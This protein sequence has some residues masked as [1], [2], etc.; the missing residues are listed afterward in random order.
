MITD[1]DLIKAWDRI[2]RTPDGALIYRYF[3][4]IIMGNLDDLDPSDRALRSHAARRRFAAEL[5]GLMAKGLD[6]SGG[7]TDL[8]NDDAGQPSGRPV[9]FRTNPRPAGHRR[10][11]NRDWLIRNDPELSSLR[12]TSNEPAEG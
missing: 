11:S 7:R 12:V 1:D 2:A 9:V 10:E 6:E 5:M 4:K 3:Q 8:P